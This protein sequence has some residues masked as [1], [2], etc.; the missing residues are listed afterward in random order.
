MTYDCKRCHGVFT[1]RDPDEPGEL[2]DPCAHVVV[3]ELEQENA[4]L[5]ADLLAGH[6]RVLRC[7]FCGHEYIAGTPTHKS[8]SLAEHV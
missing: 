7:A 1:P 5:R 6:D 4:K 8:E 3:A 2:C